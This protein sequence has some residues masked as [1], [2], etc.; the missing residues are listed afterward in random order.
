MGGPC[1][2]VYNIRLQYPALIVGEST[3]KWPTSRRFTPF[4]LDTGIRL[5]L[6]LTVRV[7]GNRQNPKIGY[8]AICLLP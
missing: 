2:G 7:T 8:M 4:E 3:R 5:P 6:S 1:L